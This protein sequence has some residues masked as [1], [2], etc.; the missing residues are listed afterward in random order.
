MKAVLIGL[1]IAT[2]LLNNG[3]KDEGE[4]NWDKDNETS[5]EA[6]WERILE[7]DREFQNNS[8][9]PFRVPRKL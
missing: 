3:I 4:R 5:V 7:A 9:K 2:L 6:R 8:N 1:T